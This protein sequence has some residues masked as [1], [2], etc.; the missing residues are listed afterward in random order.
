[1]GGIYALLEASSDDQTIWSAVL[2]RVVHNELRSGRGMRNHRGV[3]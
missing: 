3:F 1:M 2:A